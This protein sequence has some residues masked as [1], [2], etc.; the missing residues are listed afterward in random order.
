MGWYVVHTYSGYENK[1]KTNIEKAIENRPEL[2]DTI[3]EVKVPMQEVTEVKNGVRKTSEKK[4]FPGYVLIHMDA[5]DNSAWYVVRNTRGV[6][7]FVGPGSKPVPL[8]EDEM[9]ALSFEGPERIR[10]DVAEGDMVNVIAGVWVGT[11]GVVKRVDENKQVVTINVELFGRET[12]V[13]IGFA[14]I[15]KM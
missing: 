9:K 6:T 11:V 13:E 3:L 5:D 8:T 15:K 12:P 14:D 7:G 2:R 10:V 1:V 4:M